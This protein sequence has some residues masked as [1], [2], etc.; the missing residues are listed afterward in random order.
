MYVIIL[1]YILLCFLGLTFSFTL[2][3]TISIRNKCEFL[4]Q[5]QILK[6]CLS[7]LGL[8]HTAL[9]C[10]KMVTQK[11]E[12]NVLASCDHILMCTMTY[13]ICLHLFNYFVLLKVHFL[14][15]VWDMCAELEHPFFFFSPKISIKLS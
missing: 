7:V 10:F 2:P 14:S 9:L 1:D 5:V 3:L 12:R 6:F 11:A 4:F 15:Q 8:H 13:V